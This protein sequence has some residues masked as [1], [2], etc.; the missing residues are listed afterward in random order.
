MK[1]NLN[2]ATVA[3]DLKHQLL[4]PGTTRKLAT[5]QHPTGRTITQIVSCLKDRTP[6]LAVMLAHF[7]GWITAELFP[8]EV[9][10]E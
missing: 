4:T 6:E 2:L 3:A 1:K 10:R 8:A 9:S 5:G 7:L